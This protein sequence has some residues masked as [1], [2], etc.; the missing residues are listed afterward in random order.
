MRI[1]QKFI[2]N[3]TKML[4]KINKKCGAVE[5]KKIKVWNV[6]NLKKINYNKKEMK[7]GP[8][9]IFLINIKNLLKKYRIKNNKTA[10]KAEFFYYCSKII[11]EGK[12]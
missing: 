5:F 12:K 10:L 2:S 8:Q 1:K 3:Y 6:I 4:L 9:L 7:D 11:K